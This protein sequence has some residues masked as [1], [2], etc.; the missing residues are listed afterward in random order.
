M[1]RIAERL[2]RSEQLRKLQ[3][4]VIGQ[5]IAQVEFDPGLEV[6]LVGFGHE[7]WDSGFGIGDSGWYAGRRRRATI[8]PE[9]SAASARDPGPLHA[10][11]EEPPKPYVGTGTP[12]PESR[13]PALTHPDLPA[14]AM[15]AIKPTPLE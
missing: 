13:I 9:N 15:P 2:L 4:A 12:N 8:A 10:T 11:G 6:A 1:R 5:A 3:V 7:S 14:D